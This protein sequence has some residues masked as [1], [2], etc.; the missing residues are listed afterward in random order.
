MATIDNTMLCGGAAKPDSGK[1][2]T[3]E[4]TKNLET[5]TAATSAAANVRQN[6]ILRN[7]LLKVDDGKFL[8][9]LNEIHGLRN[10]CLDCRFFNYNVDDEYRCTVLG[11]C[12]GVTFSDF[13]KSYL[14]W[15]IGVI[16][17]EE[18]LANHG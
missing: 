10:E 11:Y 7:E 14:L 8:P 9:I 12:I 1:N 5:N 15:K 13:F 18:H 17:K 2:P 4:A 16:P 3:I 6:F